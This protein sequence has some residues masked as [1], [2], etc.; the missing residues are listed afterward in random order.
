VAKEEEHILPQALVELN[1]ISNLSAIG[2]ML[3]GLAKR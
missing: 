3:D 2:E 1:A